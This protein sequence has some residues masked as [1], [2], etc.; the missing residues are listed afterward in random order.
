MSKYTDEMITEMMAEGT[1][2]YAMAEAFAEKYADKGLTTRSVISKIKN[3]GLIYHPKQK[4]AP[5]QKQIRKSDMVRGIA[6][7]LEINYDAIAG[8]AK[9]DKRALAQLQDTISWR[10]QDDG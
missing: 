1:W 8:L 4:A 5:A 9:A 2:N 6:K 7:S 10:M 3:L